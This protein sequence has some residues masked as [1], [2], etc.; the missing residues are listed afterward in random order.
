MPEKD[1]TSYSLLTYFWVFGIASMGGFVSFMRKVQQGH[2]RA[3]NFV[4][5]VG[6]ISA[7]AFAGVITFYLCEQSHVDPLYTAALVGITGH[8]GSRALF[9]FEGWLQSKFPSST[10]E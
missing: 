4:E 1:P 9:M 2:A 5:F 3:W 6:E 7:S 8:M 10:P